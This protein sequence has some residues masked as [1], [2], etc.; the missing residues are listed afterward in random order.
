MEVIKCESK[1]EVEIGVQGG[2]LHREA[3]ERRYGPGAELLSSENE[4]AGFSLGKLM[5]RWRVGGG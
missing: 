2:D 5:S 1:P 3:K 4:Q